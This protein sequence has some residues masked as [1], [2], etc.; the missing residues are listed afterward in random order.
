MQEMG[1]NGRIEET[2]VMPGN[3]GKNNYNQSLAE[4]SECR[5][6]LAV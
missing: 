3:I 4:E 1:P 5:K 6:T 2:V